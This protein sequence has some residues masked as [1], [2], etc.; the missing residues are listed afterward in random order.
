MVKNYLVKVKGRKNRVEIRVF[1]T[2]TY[3][4]K[5]YYLSDIVTSLKSAQKLARHYRTGYRS[6]RFLAT[7]KGY[8]YGKTT[9]VWGVYTRE[10]K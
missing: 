9:V 6:S 3:R 5:R 2:I 1:E 10:K 8:K 4:N 7:I